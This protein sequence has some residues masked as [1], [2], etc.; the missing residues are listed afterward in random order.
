M[1]N[2][3]VERGKVKVFNCPEGSGLVNWLFEE[4]K[5]SR[6]LSRVSGG[7]RGAILVPNI[8]RMQK[9]LMARRAAKTRFLFRWN[10]RDFMDF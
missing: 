7:S 9:K 1:S 3:E 6:N 8:G 5:V 10:M 2:T 4:K